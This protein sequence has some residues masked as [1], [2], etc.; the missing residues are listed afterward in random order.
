MKKIL[1]LAAGALA[2]FF[3][4]GCA[5]IPPGAERGPDRTMA[6]TV[7]IE[8]SEPGARIEVNG[9]HAGNTPA[10]VKIFGDPDG[11][12]HDFGSDYYVIRA[13]PLAANQFAQARFFPTGRL[14][15][16]E[17]RIPER[18]YFDMNRP[19]P[20]YPPPPPPVYYYGPP[21]YYYGPA[22]YYHG[23]HIHRRW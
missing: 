17:G 15:M 2:A 4:A 14:F 18:I 12:F 23:P 10:Q 19:P 11:T 22:P 1:F 8:A 9:E 13:F 6:Y 5:T 7:L 3:L 20:A 16:P 21:V